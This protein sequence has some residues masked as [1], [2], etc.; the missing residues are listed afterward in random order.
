MNAKK[1]NK[2]LAPLII[3][4]ITIGFFTAAYRFIFVKSKEDER[5][6]QALEKNIPET[7]EFN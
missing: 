3:A 2:V 1:P 4:G 5:S 7:D 6:E